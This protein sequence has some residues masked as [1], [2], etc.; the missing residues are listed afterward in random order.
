MR[1]L[2]HLFALM[3][4]EWTAYVVRLKKGSLVDIAILVT[5]VLLVAMLLAILIFSVLGKQKQESV[6]GATSGVVDALEEDYDKDANKI[7]D[8]EYDGVILAETE[9]AGEEYV[10]NTLFIGDSNTYRMEVMGKTTWQNNLSAVGMGIGHVTGTKCMYFSGY[11]SPVTVVQAVKLMQPQRIIITYGTNNTAEST[12]TFIEWYRTALEQI[13]EAYPYADIIINSIPP[14]AQ[15][16]SYP[17]ITMKTI[18]AFNKALVELAQEEGYTF[19]NSAEVLKDS[20]GYAKAEYM[21]SSDGIHLSRE[22]MDVLFEYIRTHAHETEDTRPALTSIPTHIATP[23]EFFVPKATPAP[24]SSSTQATATPTP[25]PTPT[26]TPTA[27]P[28]PTPEATV[29]PHTGAAY[30]YKDGIMPT[31]TTGATQ[32]WQ[33]PLCGATWEQAEGPLGHSFAGNGPTCDRCDEPNPNYVPPASSN[34]VVPPSSA[35]TNAAST[36]LTTE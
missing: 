9:D 14:V 13:H 25:T 32:V 7:V 15:K 31:C 28:T 36:P 17:N 34:P 23:E 19:L 6:S 8:S 3:K 16:R 20:S 24:E 29:C 27:T 35:Q 22:G 4:K 10:D 21:E 33:C 5:A 26:A 18:D 11:S 2:Q 1:Q 12:E 30:T